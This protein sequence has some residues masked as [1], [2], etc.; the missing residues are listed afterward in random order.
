MRHLRRRRWRVGVTH[1]ELHLTRRVFDRIEH[2]QVIGAELERAVDQAVRVEPGIAAI[3]RDLVVQIHLRVGPVPLRDDDL[4][5]DPLRSWRRRRQLACRYAIGPVGKARHAQVVQ[6]VEHPLSGLPRLHATLPRVGARLEAAERFGNLTR[7][8]V[9]KLMA[10]P[11]PARLCRANPVRLIA[12][13][14]RD[15]VAL[16]PVPGNSVFAG[17]C[18]SE[19]Q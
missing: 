17:G 16:G 18:S 2:W 5:L 4:S 12:D 3:G 1:R 13:V 8:L 11:A 15:A 9:A 6:P 14:R 7:R 19:N 10:G